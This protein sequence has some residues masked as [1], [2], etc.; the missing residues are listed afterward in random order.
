[1]LLHKLLDNKALW[2]ARVNARS[3]VRPGQHLEL[4]ID[5]RSMHFFDPESGLS[6]GHKDAAAVAAEPVDTVAD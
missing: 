1:M 3:H 4:A 2:T 5:T 6:I